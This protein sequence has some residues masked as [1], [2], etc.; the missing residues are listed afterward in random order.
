MYREI[1]NGVDQDLHLVVN[2][3]MIATITHTTIGEAIVA[4]VPEAIMKEMIIEEEMTLKETTIDRENGNHKIVAG[5]ETVAITVEGAKISE[6]IIG[7]T[8]IGETMVLF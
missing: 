6:T 8:I 3:V 5:M 4:I 7:I 2:I 1:I